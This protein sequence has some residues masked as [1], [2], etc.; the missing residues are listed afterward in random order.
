MTETYKQY[1]RAFLAL[2]AALLVTFQSASS[3]QVVNSGEIVQMAV[4]GLGAF[5]TYLVPAAAGAWVAKTVAMAITTTLTALGGF[6]ANG[7][8]M[9]STLWANVIIAGVLTLI[10]AF[11]PGPTDPELDP[12]EDPVL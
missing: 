6:L 5:T 7:T 12:F 1:L 11:V 4:V 10:S 8:E 3:D 9:T 2:L